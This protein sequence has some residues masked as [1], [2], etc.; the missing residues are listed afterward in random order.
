[1]TARMRRVII[2]AAGV[3]A[4]CSACG[5]DDTNPFSIG[6]DL[7][8]QLVS[9]REEL[10]AV[11]MMEH[12]M[13]QYGLSLAL[14]ENKAYV[15]RTTGEWQST[16]VGPVT[17]EQAERFG[18]GGL[19]E[20]MREPLAAFV[21]TDRED[22]WTS[23]ERC[24]TD[25]ED[26]LGGRLETTLNDWIA[27]RNLVDDEMWVSLSERADEVL[28]P[29]AECFE[30]ATGLRVEDE[31]AYIDGELVTSHESEA[32]V[33]D[34]IAV[35]PEPEWSYEVGSAERSAAAAFTECAQDSDLTSALRDA[36]RDARDELPSTI[37]D[38]AEVIETEM[39]DL[40]EMM[41]RLLADARR[42]VE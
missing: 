7:F 1:M 14:E 15:A 2:I 21:H 13:P 27:L 10:R 34:G 4:C 41:G 20:L 36:S 28:A 33:L 35:V 24:E 30:R 5:E 42:S 8:E 22:Y 12:G 39:R 19:G 3:G 31:A 17:A 26:D 11:C 16:E 37:Y 18:F 29:T 23:W 38:E 40:V 6:D 32:T 25:I 9:G